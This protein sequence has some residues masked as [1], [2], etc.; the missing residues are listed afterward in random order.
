MKPEQLFEVMGGIDA[1]WLI[2]ADAPPKARMR[3]RRR[4]VRAACASVVVCSVCAVIWTVQGKDALPVQRIAYAVYEQRQQ[5]PETAVPE[6]EMAHRLEWAMREGVPNGFGGLY[7]DAKGQWVIQ[8]CDDSEAVRRV[9]REMAGTDTVQFERVRFSQAYLEQLLERINQKVQDGTLVSI[10]SAGLH[11]QENC[12]D[13]YL[14]AADKQA[15]ATLTALDTQGRG[16][17]LNV[18]LVEGIAD[19]APLAGI[20]REEQAPADERLT[21][22]Q[23]ALYEEQGQQRLAFSLQNATDGQVSYDEEP[24][25]QLWAQET[26][27]QV[28]VLPGVAWPDIACMLEAGRSHTIQVNLYAAYGTL[29]PGSYR[30]VKVLYGQAGQTYAVYAPFAVPMP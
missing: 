27:K 26:W 6:N 24:R 19:G 1:K 3:V 15:L 7:L 9:W 28:P 8:L 21:A 10:L 12:V 11:T 2:E 13:V 20:S 22:Q 14:R 25:L 18:Y 17:A 4:W 30:F 5:Y 23:I 16:D 29:P